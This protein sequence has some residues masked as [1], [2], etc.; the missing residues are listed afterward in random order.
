LLFFGGFPGDLEF[1][2]CRTVG[3]LT[4]PFFIEKSWSFEQF[5]ENSPNPLPHQLPKPTFYEKF[6]FYSYFIM[7]EERKVSVRKADQLINGTKQ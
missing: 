3:F 2:D 7:F 4:R 5:K 1:L 6:L